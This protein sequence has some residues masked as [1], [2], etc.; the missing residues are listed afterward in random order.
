L[1]WVVV[2]RSRA[3]LFGGNR[4]PYLARREAAY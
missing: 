2:G 4:Y 1:R 3:L